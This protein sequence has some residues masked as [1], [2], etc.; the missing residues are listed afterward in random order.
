[1][2]LNIPH[3][4]WATSAVIFLIV[5]PVNPCW[6]LK[7]QWVPT[8]ITVHIGKEANIPC[9]FLNTSDEKVNIT[10]LRIQRITRK[11]NTTIYLTTVQQYLPDKAQMKVLKIDNVQKNDSGL[12]M[13]KVMVGNETYNSCGTYLRVKEPQFFLFFNIGEATK[14]RVIT[15]EG[16]ILLLCAIIPGTF[17]LYRK[18]LENISVL[19]LKQAEGENLY[20]GLNL[21]D[22]SMYEDISR[23]LQ[24]TY[25]DVGTMRA[26]DIQLEKP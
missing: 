22:C 5:L 7:M 2:Q 4:K 21:E 19:S 20:E 1:M 14:N 9:N 8:S 11:Q 6:S 12:Y 23:G 3:L 24:A 25:E 10:W 13:C 18:R 16:V 26:M 17:L 15:A